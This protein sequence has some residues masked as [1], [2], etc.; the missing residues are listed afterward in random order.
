[1]LH[2]LDDQTG[3]FLLRVSLG[4]LLLP[5]GIAKLQGGVNDVQR[6]VVAAGLPEPLGY[7]VFVGELLAP[8]MLLVG[9]HV[10]WAGLLVVLNMLAAIA[11]VHSH[12]LL[13]FSRQGTLVLELQYFFLM[14]AVVVMFVGPGRWAIHA[15]GVRP[16]R[17]ARRG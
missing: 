2:R 4:L 15:D 8:L 6:M 16:G 1:M 17:T 7:A 10:R 5:H 13:A 9:Y 11:I 14:S 3:K 12:E